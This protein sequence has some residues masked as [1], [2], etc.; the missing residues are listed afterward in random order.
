MYRTTYTSYMCLNESG[1]CIYNYSLVDIWDLVCSKKIK[2]CFVDV[3]FNSQYFLLIIT[4]CYNCQR[5]YIMSS[6]NS[7]GGHVAVCPGQSAMDK[8][9]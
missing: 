4:M 3:K 9:C 7:G 1:I 6:K 2:K 5:R 8:F